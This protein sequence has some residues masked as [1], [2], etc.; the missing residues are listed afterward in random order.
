MVS[1]AWVNSSYCLQ[2]M[3][4]WKE[5]PKDNKPL[6]SLDKYIFRFF[7]FYSTITFCI[8][9]YIY[10]S[11]Y[12]PIQA[13]ICVLE[14]EVIRTEAFKKIIKLLLSNLPSSLGKLITKGQLSHNTIIDLSHPAGKH[15]LTRMFAIYYLSIFIPIYVSL[16]LTYLWI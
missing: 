12:P 8:Y 16:I 3:T 7:S 14:H 9:I 2:E 5:L 4:W 10:L 1:M 11:I 6:V 15:L 13:L